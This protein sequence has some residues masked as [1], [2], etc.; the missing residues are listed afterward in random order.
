MVF[1]CSH[2][3]RGMHLSLVVDESG[4]TVCHMV[5]VPLETVGSNGTQKREGEQA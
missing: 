5:G 3:I 1:C 4:V 2:T